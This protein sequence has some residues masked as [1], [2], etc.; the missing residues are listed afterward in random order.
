MRRR[1]FRSPSRIRIPYLLTAMIWW[2]AVGV[3]VYHLEPQTLSDIG[4]P[5]M[6]L[7]WWVLWFLA[8]FFSLYGLGTKGRRALWWTTGILVFSFLRLLG[9][10]TLLNAVLIISLLLVI[11]YYV[12]IESK[13]TQGQLEPDE[14]GS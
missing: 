3:V 5:G 13:T 4:M 11:E 9:L 2:A 6:Y 10:G 1:K 14:T 12:R 8:L 7:P